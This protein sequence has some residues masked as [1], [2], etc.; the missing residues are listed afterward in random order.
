MDS[1]VRKKKKAKGRDVQH[2]HTQWRVPQSSTQPINPQVA[3]STTCAH[4]M[5]SPS[6]PAVHGVPLG[7]R[8][9][10][11][12]DSETSRKRSTNKSAARPA[13]TAT[14][15]ATAATT[16]TTATATAK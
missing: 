10:V 12:P 7:K 13:A 1:H 9:A 11:R 5:A 8:P 15:A 6:A 2:G 16:S 14:T 3:A 4:S